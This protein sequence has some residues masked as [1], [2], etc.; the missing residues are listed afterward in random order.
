MVSEII[1]LHRLFNVYISIDLNFYCF[2]QE[3]YKIIYTLNFFIIY[4]LLTKMLAIL[5]I[6]CALVFIRPCFCLRKKFHIKFL[7]VIIILRN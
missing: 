1:V 2:I 7:I 5:F 6:F 3:K 4:I